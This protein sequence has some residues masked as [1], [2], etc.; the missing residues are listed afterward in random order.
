MISKRF[1]RDVLV[2]KKCIPTARLINGAGA[3]VLPGTPCV[4]KDVVRGKEITI[5]TEPCPCCGQFAR[6]S[7]ISRNDLE[8]VPEVA[9]LGE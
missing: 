3:G 7:H 6:I 2:G 9:I 8:I 4:I 1:T 5:E